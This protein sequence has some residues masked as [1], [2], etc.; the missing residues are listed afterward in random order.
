MET[1]EITDDASHRRL[2]GMLMP[3]DPIATAM[4]Q[5]DLLQLGSDQNHMLAASWARFRM[6]TM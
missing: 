4:C 5:L 2:S 3:L 6:Y 1:T